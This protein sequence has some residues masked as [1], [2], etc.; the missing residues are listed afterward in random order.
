MMFNTI[1]EYERFKLRRFEYKIMLMIF[2]VIW[3]QQSSLQ[4]LTVISD[5]QSYCGTSAQGTEVSQSD[6]GSGTPDVGNVESL[7]ANNEE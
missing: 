1:T 6:V 3:Y 2:N 5:A 4:A 7:Q